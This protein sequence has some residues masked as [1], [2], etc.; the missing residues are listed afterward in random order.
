M[1]ESPQLAV[2]GYQASVTGYRVGYRIRL[3]PSYL[4]YK[5]IVMPTATLGTLELAT[6]L[7][8]ARLKDKAYGLA[9]KRDLAARTG[10]DYSVGALYTTLQRLEDKGLLTSRHSE[11]LP[12]R[13]GRSRRHFTLTGAGA[14]ALRQAERHAASIWGGVGKTLRPRLA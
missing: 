10:R 2:V 13:G 12:V 6:L 1:A 7:A 14:R 11:P 3:R 8:V 5:L 4:S 9:I